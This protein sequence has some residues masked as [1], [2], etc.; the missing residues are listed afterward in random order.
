MKKARLRC[1]R[2]PAWENVWCK[3]FA[4]HTA[5]A[6]PPCEYGRKLMHN[7]YMREYMR[8]YNRK[9]NGK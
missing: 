3:V 7:E 6:S 8:N 9:G 4:K 5:G 1:G 2:C